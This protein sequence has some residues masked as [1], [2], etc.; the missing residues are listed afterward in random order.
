M[1]A[2][3]AF[4]HDTGLRIAEACSITTEEARSWPSPPWW[5][6]RRVCRRHAAVTRVIGKG[7]RERVVILT[8]RAVDSAQVLLTYTDNGRLFKWTDRGVRWVFEQVGKKA[9]VHLHPHRLRHTLA[10]ELVE[11]GVPI[12]VVADILGHSSSEITKLYWQASQRSK[13]AALSRRRR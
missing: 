3:V 1:K 9:G 4:L 11:G 10:T 12:E 6:R 7:D 8:R 5:C 2:A 13:V